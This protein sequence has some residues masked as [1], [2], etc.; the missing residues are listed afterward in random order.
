MYHVGIYIDSFLAI[1]LT[2]HH[3]L[4]QFHLYFHN[5]IFIFDLKS[6]FLFKIFEVT[7]WIF[8]SF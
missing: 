8:T 7:F 2:H 1:F 4:F 6:F 5:L 3:S